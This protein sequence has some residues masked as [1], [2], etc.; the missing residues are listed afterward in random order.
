MNKIKISLILLVLSAFLIGCG[1]KEPVVETNSSELQETIAQSCAVGCVIYGRDLAI[2]QELSEE[3]IA[4]YIIGCMQECGYNIT[5][6]IEESE[7]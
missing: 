5:K 7:V 2:S 1:S 4:Y 6:F 3:L